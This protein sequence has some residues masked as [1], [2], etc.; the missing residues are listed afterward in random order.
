MANGM[1]AGVFLC[2][3]T[4]SDLV[5]NKVTTTIIYIYTYIQPTKMLFGIFNSFKSIERC[6]QVKE[7]DNC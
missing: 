5:S 6:S 3:T 7:F 1:C 4:S 2:F